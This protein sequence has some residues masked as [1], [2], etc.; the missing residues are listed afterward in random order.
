MEQGKITS[1]FY[2]EGV[3]L[4]HVQPVRNR[5]E[6]KNVPVVKRGAEDYA[7]P[8]V[9]QRVVMEKLDDGTRFI[10]GVLAKNDDGEM[11]ASLEEGEMVFQF[12]AGTKI[13]VSKTAAGHTV[14]V[15]ASDNV[16]IDGIDFDEHTHDYTDDTDTSSSTKTTNPP[17]TE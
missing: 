8:Q 10:L 6:Y 15:E 14:E 12:D 4:C 16:I 7:L 5:E 1:A 17:N 13:S 9:G 3:A 2:K 11:P